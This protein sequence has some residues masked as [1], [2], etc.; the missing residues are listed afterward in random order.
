MGKKGLLASLLILVLCCFFTSDA[1]AKGGSASDP[2]VS[3]SW[4]DAYVKQQ[5]SALE[6][7]IASLKQQV[8]GLN[9]MNITLT[10]GN[11]MAE[12]NDAYLPID[13]ENSLV[14]PY[15]DGNNRTLVPVRFVSEQLGAEVQWNATTREVSIQQ[16]STFIQ[17]Y[18]GKTEYLVNGEPRTMDTA[19]VINSGWNRTM[20]PVRF[21][22]ET[23]GCDVDWEP[24]N[25]S[26]KYVYISR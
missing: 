7:K 6:E 19:P 20:V 23:L 25:D 5:F 2:L 16:G 1:G 10:I 3:Q 14:V 26:T 11:S 15:I 24:K 8:S 12:V 9:S 4:V 21:I 22:A 17:M 18:V 13:E